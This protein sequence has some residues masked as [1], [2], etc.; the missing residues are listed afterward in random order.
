MALAV[1]RKVF[2]PWFMATA[3]GLFAVG[4][5]GTL[6][7]QWATECRKSVLT[8]DRYT[9]LA[10]GMACW[11]QVCAILV[12]WFGRQGILEA[13]EYAGDG[14]KVEAGRGMLVV[15]VI[16]LVFYFFLY[17]INWS[18]TCSNRFMTSI[19]GSFFRRDP[20]YKEDMYAD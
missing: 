18:V 20:Q 5:F 12:L 15:H 3:G 13:L 19:S 17:L 6:K 4:Y 7:S 2:M 8:C 1:R 10:C 9:R 16:V 14:T 11:V